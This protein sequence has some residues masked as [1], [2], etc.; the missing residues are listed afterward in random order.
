[1]DRKMKKSKHFYIQ[2]MLDINDKKQFK[3]ILK[4]HAGSPTKA[5]KIQKFMEKNF[6]FKYFALD[7]RTSSR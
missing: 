2:D 6:M 3:K 1:M 4:Q 5:N 7:E